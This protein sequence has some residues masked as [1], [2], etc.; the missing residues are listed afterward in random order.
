VVNLC[1][2][3]LTSS[4]V[5]W[6]LCLTLKTPV[7]HSFVNR[8]VMS[9]TGTAPTTD[10]AGHDLVERWR[11][12]E[13]DEALELEP[14]SPVSWRVCDGRVTAGPGRLLGFVQE[15]QGTFEV[16]QVADRFIWTMFP[17]MQD[18]LTHVA[19]TRDAVLVARRA[20]D[21]AWLE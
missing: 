7:S 4:H 10:H 2:A 12:S 21:L 14:V 6:M 8:G 9:R 1:R 19:A 5:G 13:L 17:T 16:M 20:G 11:F 15:R 18:A 3:S